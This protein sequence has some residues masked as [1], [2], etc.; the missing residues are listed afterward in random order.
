MTHRLIAGVDEVG[1]GPLAGPVVA[2]AVVLDP[3]RPIEGLRDSKELTPEARTRLA[4]EIRRYALGFALAAADQA[5][6]DEIN[7]LQASLVAMQRAV[8]R[9]RC[10]FDHVVVDGNRAPSFDGLRTRYSV[11]AR[12]RG[13]QSVPS[14]S[15]ASILAKVCRD[16]LMCRWDRRFPGYAFS[17]NKGYPTPEHCEALRRLGPCPLH[18]RSFAPVRELLVRL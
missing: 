2:A 6:I 11:E 3:R 12:V 1:R 10:V 8:L 14:V 18:R 15:A 9:L 13:D 16:R 7:I 5:E 17:R 4:R